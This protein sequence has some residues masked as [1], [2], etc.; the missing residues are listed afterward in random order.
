[1][2]KLRYVWKHR[3]S[4]EIKVHFPPVDATGKEVEHRPEFTASFAPEAILE[5]KY[6]ERLLTNPRYAGWFEEV[7]V[8]ALPDVE[9]VC[10]VCGKAMK[11]K[12]GLGSHMRIHTKT[13]RGENETDS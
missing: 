13:Q 6:A 3:T 8:V 4:D 11:S 10:E 7:D 2:K 12:A 9:L 5:D 1:M